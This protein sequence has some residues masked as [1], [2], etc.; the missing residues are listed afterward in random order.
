M[1]RLLLLPVFIILVSC[2]GEMKGVISVKGNEPHS[3]TAF[4]AENGNFYK[5]E[6]ALSD[7]LREKYQ[8]TKIRVKG[9]LIKE[10]SGFGP[11]VIEVSEVVE[12]YR[13]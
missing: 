3:Y 10:K 6:G 2:M 4:T 8:G 9:K 7:E 13:D 1:K 12:V 5:V 11:G